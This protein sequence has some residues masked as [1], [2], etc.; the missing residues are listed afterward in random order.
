MSYQQQILGTVIA[1]VLNYDQLCIEIGENPAI[2]SKKS[3]YA[4][5]D[6]RSIQ[7]SLLEKRTNSVIR[8]APDLRGKF[9]RGLNVMY[10]VD[11]PLPF[12]AQKFGD[13]Q[14]NRVVMDYQVD[15][16]QQHQHGYRMFDDGKIHD[17]SNDTDQRS[18]S[19]GNNTGSNTDFAGQPFAETRPRNVSFYY[20]IKIN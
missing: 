20:Y 8:T 7:G 14:D 6:G 5:C 3:S 12:D 11:Q 17:M 9:L 1:S 16:F 19:Y 13:T 2:D 18:A 15:A 10:S 4:P